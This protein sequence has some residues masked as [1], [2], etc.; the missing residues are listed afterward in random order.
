MNKLGNGLEQ[1]T[2]SSLLE[3]KIDRT[4]QERKNK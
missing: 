2:V 1:S 4:K 3:S